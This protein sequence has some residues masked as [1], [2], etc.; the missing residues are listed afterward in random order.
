MFCKQAAEEKLFWPRRK[1]TK[2][3]ATEA[4]ATSTATTGVQN[5]MKRMAWPSGMAMQ[6]KTMKLA[7]MKKPNGGPS[8]SNSDA[9]DAAEKQETRKRDVYAEKHGKNVGEAPAGN[10]HSQCDNDHP[11]GFG[12]GFTATHTP[13]ENKEVLPGTRRL[14]LGGGSQRQWNETRPATAAARVKRESICPQAINQ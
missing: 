14:A 11:Q 13:C 3:Q 4:G 6:P 2:C 5:S 8:R 12:S 10:G 9:V 1:E 7:T